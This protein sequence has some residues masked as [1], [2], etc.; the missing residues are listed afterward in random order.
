MKL[1]LYGNKNTTNIT[2]LSVNTEW[3][4]FKTKAINKTIETSEDLFWWMTSYVILIKR[5]STYHVYNLIAPCT[6][7]V[8]SIYIFKFKLMS[9]MK[10]IF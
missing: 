10:N 3:N 9:S 1:L 6:G 2:H 7:I 8:L 4:V 5:S